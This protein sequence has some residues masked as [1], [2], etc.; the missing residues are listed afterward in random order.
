ML[1][2]LRKIVFLMISV[3]FFTSCE[4]KPSRLESECKSSSN[5]EECV[6][7]KDY[8]VKHFLKNS[9]KYNEN[10]MISK[11]KEVNK[12]SNQW[13]GVNKLEKKVLLAKS[14]RNLR[15][16]EFIPLEGEEYSKALKITKNNHL[17]KGYIIH[18]SEEL[19]NG[20]TEE[21]FSIYSQDIMDLKFSKRYFSKL[22]VYKFGFGSKLQDW[23]A[24]KC[25]T[26][27]YSSPFCKGQFIIS[28][29]INKNKYFKSNYIVYYLEKFMF[30]HQNIDELIEEN[31]KK[32]SLLA[33][34]IFDKHYKIVEK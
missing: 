23:L 2:A 9:Y 12:Y 15:F 5:Y 13:F 28:A 6:N 4:K 33:V 1:C 17:I 18:N 3:T 32:A 31:N 27:L 11:I 19:D 21:Y 10:R 16:R 24:E 8:F 7:N 25:G 20:A 14:T 29:D 26:L 34:K 30:S 22:N